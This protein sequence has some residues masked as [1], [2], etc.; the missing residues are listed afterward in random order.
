MVLLDDLEVKFFYVK[1]PVYN[2]FDVY[3]VFCQ[4]PWPVFILC[5]LV[6]L[7]L[8]KWNSFE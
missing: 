8:V 3:V 2:V 1:L 4:W 6:Y 5:W 7:D